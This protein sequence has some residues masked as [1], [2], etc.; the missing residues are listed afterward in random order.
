MSRRPIDFVY[1]CDALCHLDSGHKRRRLFR[2]LRLLRSSGRLSDACTF[3]IV[4]GFR[5]ASFVRRAVD[6]RPPDGCD[7]CAEERRIAM[8][9]AESGLRINAMPRKHDWF[10]TAARY[11]SG[12][13]CAPQT[14]THPQKK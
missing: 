9:L 7:R 14:H 5:S 13:G 12:C 1:A 6:A 4:D 8:R 10:R 3:V 2:N 11:A